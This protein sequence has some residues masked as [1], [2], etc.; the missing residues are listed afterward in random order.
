MDNI[1]IFFVGAQLLLQIL[2]IKYLFDLEANGCE[3]AMD[4]KRN[5]ILFYLVLNTIFAV[6]S[7]FTNVLRTTSNNK[8]GSFLMSAYSVGGILNI[9]FII[10]YVNMLKAKHCDCSESVYRDL[11]YVFAI[12]DALVFVMALLLVFYVILFSSKGKGTKRHV[13][14][15][16]R[17]LKR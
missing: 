3:C 10:E 11:L 15:R 1:T 7:M 9:V 4:Y 6:L 12:I 16:K 14:R 8:L 13:V 5:Y 2:I 17:K